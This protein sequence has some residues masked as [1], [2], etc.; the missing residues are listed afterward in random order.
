MIQLCAIGNSPYVNLDDEK[1]KCKMKRITNEL[2]AIFAGF[3]TAYVFQLM[4]VALIWLENHQVPFDF[5]AFIPLWT[6]QLAILPVFSW[7]YMGVFGVKWQKMWN[8]IT[9][10]A[11]KFIVPFVIIS[12]LML[13]V[14]PTALEFWQFWVADA[15]LSFVAAFTVCRNLID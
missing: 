15:L 3:V 1:G 11:I 9:K 12:C 14:L 4:M 7:L 5:T 10:K 6:I 2:W 13:F 8:K